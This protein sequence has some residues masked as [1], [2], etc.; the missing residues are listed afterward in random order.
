MTPARI[1]R[2]D[3]SRNRRTRSAA[4]SMRRRQLEARRLSETSPIAGL[5]TYQY[6]RPAR[7]REVF[8]PRPPRRRVAQ[9]S[10]SFGAVGSST[11]TLPP[12]ASA[13]PKVVSGDQI[14]ATMRDGNQPLREP[15]RALRANRTAIVA[16]R[17]WVPPEPPTRTRS[18]W[19]L[20]LG[21]AAVLSTAIMALVLYLR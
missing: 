12:V 4:E 6:L 16:P 8:G 13:P 5:G 7:G 15:N 9:G 14:R 11:I 1:L 19:I 18:P 10:D 17:I 21:L 2:M 3:K 20:P